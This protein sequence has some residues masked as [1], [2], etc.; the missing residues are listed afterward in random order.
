MVIKKSINKLA[1][2]HLVVFY[3]HAK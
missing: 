2:S 1:L 3:T